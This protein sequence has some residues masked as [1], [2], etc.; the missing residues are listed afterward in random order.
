MSKITSKV[1]IDAP[2]HKVW[3]VLADFGHV[4][5]L[6]G[7]IKNSYLTSDQ[8]Q[9]VGTTRHCDLSQFGATVEERIIEWQAEE[10]LKIEIFETHNIPIVKN[11]Q[12]EFMVDDK[13]GGTELTMTISYDTTWGVLGQLMDV[14]MLKP[15]NRKGWTGFAAG[16]KHYVETGEPIN[17][18]VKVDVDPVL[19]MA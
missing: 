18:E 11:M 5:R 8:Q 12:A 1:W 15:N 4:S 19:T 10:L 17:A 16:I 3:Q 6:N 13:N 2:R 14:F 7:G 9:G